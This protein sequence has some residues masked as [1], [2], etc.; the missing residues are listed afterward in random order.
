MARK[1]K[2][3]IVTGGD[4]FSIA[5]QHRQADNIIG[6]VTLGGFTAAEALKSATG[7]AATVLGWSTGMNP[8]PDY[9][10]GVIEEQAFA[11]LIVV[12]GNPLDDIACLKRDKI[13]VVL[14]DGKCYKYTLGDDALEVV[15]K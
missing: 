3:L 4:M 7:N 1:H 2:V 6:M 11:D 15:K 13:K 12:D 8:Y 10:L 14:K 5:Y 9:K